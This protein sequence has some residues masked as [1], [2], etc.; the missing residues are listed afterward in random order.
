MI[1]K[2]P[3]QNI[4]IEQACLSCGLLNEQALLELISRVDEVDFY[5]D[6]NRLLF[7]YMKEIYQK[8][9]VVPDY[10]ALITEYRKDNSDLSF[11]EYTELF[12]MSASSHKVYYYITELLK[13][14]KARKIITV[15]QDAIDKIYQNSDPESIQE[16]IT[17][18]LSQIDKTDEIKIYDSREMFDNKSVTDFQMKPENFIKTGISDFDE[19][20][21]GLYK[22]ELITI[23]GR[24]SQ[25]KSA[26]AMNIADNQA[27]T[28]PVLYISMEMP[29]E[30]FS[31]RRIAA[32]AMVNSF[33]IQHGYRLT[34]IEKDKIKDAIEQ[35]AKDKFYL[36]D[37]AG[38]NK[39]GIDSVVR[40]FSKKHGISLL[41]VDYLQI[42]TSK[43]KEQ[44]HVRIGEDTL[45]IKNIGR[46]LKIPTIVVSSKSRGSENSKDLLSG[47]GESGKIEYDTDK[48]V[49]L[50]YDNWESNVSQTEVQGKII[51]AKNKYGP[52]GFA[53]ITFY[54]AF[55]KFI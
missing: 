32:R 41:V 48:G 29:E 1:T 38:M 10:T 33:K 43:S 11:N 45:T 25:G 52:T 6:K 53:P 22:S 55:S 34:D 37:K 20:F 12:N 21:F 3:P 27:K 44:R 14:S 2:L 26:L 36:I 13:Y 51:V 23:S 49:F 16:E 46:D 40:R 30:F 50:E 24:P 9:K 8:N 19:L 7:K 17:Y 35:L 31:I 18:N 54:K 4:E 28:E 42:M 15:S 39:E 47:F 5:L